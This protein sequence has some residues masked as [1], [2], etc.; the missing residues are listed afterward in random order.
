M[1]PLCFPFDPA[2]P[3]LRPL[4]LAIPA[5]PELILDFKKAKQDGETQ[6]I[7]IFMDECIYSK[8]KSIHDRIKHNSHL[9]FAGI[10][11]T[12]VSEK[13]LKI[14]RGKMDSRTLAF[15]LMSVVYCLYLS[16]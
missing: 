7:K 11:S 2:S 5:T 9:T 1:L 10:P 14:K 8:E 12:K 13:T 3:A 6:P 15:V 4:Q 16:S